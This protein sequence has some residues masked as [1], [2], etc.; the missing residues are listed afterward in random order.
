MAII[1]LLQPEGWKILRILILISHQKHIYIHFNATFVCVLPHTSVQIF[2]QLF[3]CL[4]L[5]YPVLSF[6]FK[7][8]TYLFMLTAHFVCCFFFCVVIFTNFS[9]QILFV[10]SQPFAFYNV[11]K[12]LSF[13]HNNFIFTFTFCFACLLVFVE[14]ICSTDQSEI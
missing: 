5:R 12:F 13:L 8:L 6:A 2:L 9:K 4:P 14:K 11:Y 3:V 10:I 7:Y 1:R